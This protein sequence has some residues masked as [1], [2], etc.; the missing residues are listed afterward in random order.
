MKRT[1]NKLLI[2]RATIV[3]LC[4]VSFAI[5]SFSQ[6]KFE[7]Y[8]QKIDDL[9]TK[10]VYSILQDYQGFIWFSTDL[11]IYRYQGTEKLSHQRIIR[12]GNEEVFKLIEDQEQNLWASTLSGNLLFLS[13]DRKNERRLSS[14]HPNAGLISYLDFDSKSGWLEF[15]HKKRYFHTIEQFETIASLRLP[16]HIRY[17][18]YTSDPFSK[19]IVS[20]EGVYL[21]TTNSKKDSC[22]VKFVEGNHVVQATG[23]EA[24]IYVSQDYFKLMQADQSKLDFSLLAQTTSEI[25]KIKVIE[26]NIYIGTR[27]G[28]Y[29]LN[30]KTKIQEGPFLTSEE[31]SDFLLDE[32]GFLWI[33]TLS[34]G[35]FKTSSHMDF[36]VLSNKPLEMKNP[37]KIVSDGKILAIGGGTNSVFFQNLSNG[38]NT[39]I[40][41]DSHK[42]DEIRFIKK[43][44]NN[45][46]IG[47]KAGLI[48]LND[49]FK[50]SLKTY[51]VSSH[52]ISYDELN[53]KIYFAGVL[54]CYD[55][56]SEFL[57]KQ[58]LLKKASY[59]TSNQL[60]LPQIEI[61]R[62]YHVASYNGNVYFASVDSLYRVKSF[63][64][65]LLVKGISNLSVTGFQLIDS[66]IYFGTKQAGIYTI[67]NQ[68]L[69]QLKIHTP[70]YISNI[71]YS[72]ESRTLYF[73]DYN[74]LYALKIDDSE[75]KVTN[76]SNLIG[77][78]KGEVK[79]IYVNN[80]I[81]H[82][83]IGDEVLVFNE[84][85]E[86]DNS[87]SPIN[88]FIDSVIGGKNNKGIVS[89]D[90]PNRMLDIYMS[91]PQYL[92]TENSSFL[93]RI[94]DNTWKVNTTGIIH[95]EELAPKE[96]TL[97]LAYQ[98][99]NKSRSSVKKIKIIVR[100]VFWE[101]TA[102]WYLVIGC[103]LIATFLFVRYRL[104]K[105]R[106]QF[107]VKEK[108]I[109]A[110][111]EKL[112]LEKRVT[113]IEQVAL[114]MQINPHFIFNVINN[115]KGLYATN[116]T[117]RAKD[118]LAYFSKFIRKVLD[119][120]KGITSLED[121][122]D[123][124]V[125]YLKLEQ[126]R[127]EQPLVY[128]INV[129]DDINMEE[130][131]IYALLL[132][133]FIENSVIHA[134]TDQLKER[135]IEI[136]ISKIDDESLEIII[137]D[138]GVGIN[139]HNK[140]K[141]MHQSKGIN[142]CRER[143]EVIGEEMNAF[144]FLLITDLSDIGE[145]GTQV[146]IIIP[147]IEL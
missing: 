1:H 94:N 31:V 47:N 147:Y 49:P 112:S 142:L 78:P 22:L 70:Q 136:S 121:E 82:V 15:Q 79:D 145:Q 77:L 3:F 90:Y 128:E 57:K 127:S 53:D 67:N 13:K 35:V 116:K 131:G 140:E 26:D 32:H 125:N 118:Y 69:E 12:F 98:N 25:I 51:E 46:W 33:S 109:K 138:N 135:K 24:S 59:K 86:L 102:F 107:L 66:V 108:L 106:E 126:I 20:Q 111:N 134:F 84:F 122:I 141:G 2:T 64:D 63:N 40:K 43:Y 37:K 92:T 11:G 95:F 75:K 23:D 80:E 60:N 120:S 27:G 52:D 45:W 103:I 100:P 19:V 56:A 72:K 30:K 68:K 44:G 91:A 97:E 144:T 137:K 132:Q 18:Y 48:V 119:S 146:K 6:S 101:T 21:K 85:N 10:V 39:L 5:G 124:T 130:V 99:F 28:Y 87:K 105:L 41:F 71:S 58:S 115:I 16:Y 36:K 129:S 34:N 8:H 143:I 14:I 83:I 113:E 73:S 76:L 74:Y 9:P 93:Y 114:R 54:N 55:E 96:Y 65:Q 123:I 29:R 133:P 117:E 110:L 81:V 61:N 88:F 104:K 139:H 17:T 7:K 42:L 62:A 4:L 50:R 89:L 38:E